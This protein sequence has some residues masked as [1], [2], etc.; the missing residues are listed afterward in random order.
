LTNATSMFLGVTLTNANYNGL[1]SGWGNFVIP[2]N[3]VTFSGGNSHYDAT[4]GGFDGIAGRLLLTGTYSWFI[5]DG[6]TP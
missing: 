5:T 2:H 1:L 3:T 4:S 6:G